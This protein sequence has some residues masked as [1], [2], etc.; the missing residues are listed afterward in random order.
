MSAE[1]GRATVGARPVEHFLC[2]VDP[3]RRP[4][5]PSRP[6]GWWQLY[7]APMSNRQCRIR[8]P[9]AARRKG[10]SFSG[11]R[12]RYHIRALL[13]VCRQV[14]VGEVILS[15]TMVSGDPGVLEI[16]ERETWN[17]ILPIM[18]ISLGTMLM[19]RC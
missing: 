15:Q 13:A 16:R 14:A 5:Q 19:W 1:V 12:K 17:I 11:P 6:G 18:W 4:G 3:A 2:L 9:D 8:G 10:G 7:C